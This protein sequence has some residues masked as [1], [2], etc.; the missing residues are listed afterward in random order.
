[1]HSFQIRLWKNIAQSLLE[2]HKALDN[3][4]EV[5]LLEIFMKCEVEKEQYAALTKDTGND[6]IWQA[7]AGFYI[8]GFACKTTS[9]LEICK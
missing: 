1:M 7:F 8:R 6:E 9:R 2:F 5:Q 4:Q 3:K